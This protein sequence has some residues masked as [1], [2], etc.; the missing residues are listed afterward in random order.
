MLFG[1]I[2]WSDRFLDFH[3]RTSDGRV[4][5]QGQVESSVEGLTEL[6][7]ALESHGPA[8]EIGIAIETCHGAWIQ[9]LLDR[10]YQI[11]PVNPKTVERF[12]EA[13]SAAGNKSDKI[14]RKV[15]AMF[16]V[17]F[18]QDCTP[19]RPDAQEI[20]SLRIACQDRVRMVEERSAKLSELKAILK[21]YYPAFLRLFANLKSK[22]A[23][24]FL[25][26][27]PTQKQMKDL[28]KRRLQN[29]L[30]RHHYSW[31]RRIA[32]MV[33]V[34]KEPSLPV[35]E[36]L[37]QAKTP[38]IFYLAGSIQILNS[39]IAQRDKRIT[40]HL[41]RL[42]EANWIRSLPGA[43]EVIAPALLACL[44]RDLQR[45]ASA[46]NAR[47][48]MGTAPV[49]KSSG[50]VRVVQFRRGCWKF[51]RRTLQ[52]FVEQSRHQCPWA[53]A[54]YIKQRNSGHDHHAA[55]C[56]LAHKW[57]KIILAMRRNGTVYNE[58]IF[59]N[60]QRRYLLKVPMLNKAI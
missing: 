10:G 50:T 30:K 21:C 45:F 12:R 20:V 8:T 29:W 37:Q 56:A 44:G 32:D 26:K 31:V 4:L 46:A 33:D 39:E 53:R 19:L 15:L 6:F 42:P 5:V 9:P 59:V 41:D 16:L 48:L 23:L 40:E 28:T 57:L 2:D 43:G 34:L 25:E 49:T 27:F 18:H 38:L 58:Q 24:Q 7:T 11:Y 35:A 17:T 3:L 51:A 47:A 14:D 1:G 36:H 13:L 54:F 60:S 22:I 52:L 55:L